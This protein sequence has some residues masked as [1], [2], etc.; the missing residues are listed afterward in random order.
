MKNKAL[1]IHFTRYLSLVLFLVLV[2]LGC[3]DSL[4]DSGN[5]VESDQDASLL[6][7]PVVDFTWTMKGLAVTFTNTS[8]GADRYKWD[9]GDAQASTEENPEH[10]YT[11][12]GIFQVTLTARTTIGKMKKVHTVAVNQDDDDGGGGLPPPISDIPGIDILDPYP[13]DMGDAGAHTP[14]SYKG[15]SLRLTDNGEPQVTPVND[16]IGVVC[17]G[18][19][20]SH[21]ECDYFISEYMPKVSSEINPKVKVV[22][23]AVGGNAIEKWMDPANDAKLWDKC[24]GTKLGAQ[25]GITADQVR[26]IYHKAANMYTGP[27]PGEDIA[28]PP[29][30]EPESD[31]FNFYENLGTFA[32]RVKTF[33]PNVQA[34]YTTSRSYGGYSPRV[35]R[36]EPLS[37][38]EGHALNAWLQDNAEVDGIWQ[39]WGPYIWAPDCSTGDVNGSDVCYVESDYQSDGVHPGV[40]AKEKIAGMLHSRLSQH[41]WYRN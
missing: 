10:V 20:N 18:M 13:I 15:L 37:Y 9:F 25:A 29:Y 7:E 27:T 24:I 14:G 17:I 16:V 39:G 40:G 32:A 1:P 22:D 12:A 41:A 30:P 3:S 34:V 11:G 19:S 6:K 35:T 36:G 31:Y 8:T 21:Q 2:Q 28:Y 5:D 33:F 4:L 23:C 38:E 26:V